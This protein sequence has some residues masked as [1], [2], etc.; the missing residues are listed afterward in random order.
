MKRLEGKINKGTRPI[1]TLEYISTQELTDQDLNDLFSGSIKLSLIVG[2]FRF[3]GD[4]RTPHKIIEYC[5]KDLE[6]FNHNTWSSAKYDEFREILKKI[7]RNVYY[8]G[9]EK[10][11]AVADMWLNNYGFK[12]KD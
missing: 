7:Y 3:N 6:W 12:I 10:C 9:Q 5:K 2:M 11:L 1:F 8:Y 4:A